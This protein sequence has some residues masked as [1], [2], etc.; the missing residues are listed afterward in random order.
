M[1]G[2]NVKYLYL[3]FSKMTHAWWMVAIALTGVKTNY[4]CSLI[5]IVNGKHQIFVKP[6]IIQLQNYLTYIIP[7]GS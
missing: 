3:C 6:Y 2:T 5:V 4:F 7:P 1:S